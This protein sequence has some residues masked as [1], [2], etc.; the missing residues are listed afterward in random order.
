MASCPICGSNA[1]EHPTRGHRSSF[2]C[3]V[4]GMF[5]ITG[6]A[7]R[8]L[9]AS[10]G[11]TA[12]KRAIL[13][14]RVRLDQSAD[15]PP[16]IDTYL[17]DAVIQGAIKLPTPPQQASNLLRRIG[18][19]VASTGEPIRG[20]APD[21]HSIIGAPNARAAIELLFELEGQKLIKGTLQRTVSG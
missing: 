4:C 12:Q 21:T 6:T 5:E 3:P 2:T 1:S 15:T 20:W 13:S 17:M 18:D 8:V 19:Q 9:A 10:E 7:Q 11:W 16:R 14:H